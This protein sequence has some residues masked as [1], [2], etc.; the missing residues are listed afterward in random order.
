MENSKD[1]QGKNTNNIEEAE[2]K[3]CIKK[4]VKLI[5]VNRAKIAAMIAAPVFVGTIIGTAT[6]AIAQ[7]VDI[8]FLNIPRYETRY[9]DS[10]INY[11][12]PGIANEENKESI[13][14]IKY[15]YEE[16][17]KYYIRK[18]VILKTK[19]DL[20]NQV[21]KIVNSNLEG[22]K[23]TFSITEEENTYEVETDVN[24]K[25]NNTKISV[26]YNS[27][28]DYDPVQKN[29]KAIVTTSCIISCSSSVLLTSLFTT[30]YSE[31]D[32]DFRDENKYYKRKIKELKNMKKA[33]NK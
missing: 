22:I 30:A 15:P 11:A 32:T 3:E 6:Y 20:T 1:V 21:D 17:D 5:R 25:D 9:V 7:N 8:S 13:I 29:N 16:K 4:Y 18:V 2:I 26:V 31:M 33:E 27:F 19:D 24:L 10:E 23:K 14:T 28:L 12:I